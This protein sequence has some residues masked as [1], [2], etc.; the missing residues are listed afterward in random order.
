MYVTAQA[1]CVEVTRSYIA[2]CFLLCAVKPP[3]KPTLVLFQRVL[4]SN[5]WEMTS[6]QVCVAALLWNCKALQAVSL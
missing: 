3:V 5:A 1:G 4:I 2:E 6:V